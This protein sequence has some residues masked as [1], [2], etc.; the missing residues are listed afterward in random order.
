VIHCRWPSYSPK[1]SFH[2]GDCVWKRDWYALGRPVEIT[3]WWCASGGLPA[4]DPTHWMPLP[5]PPRDGRR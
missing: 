5:S 4:K 3:G 2:E 1:I